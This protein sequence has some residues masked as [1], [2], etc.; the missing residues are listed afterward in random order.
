MSRAL[1][2]FFA[3]STLT[4]CAG[5][6]NLDLIARAENPLGKPG[7]SERP[8]GGETPEGLGP[9]AIVRLPGGPVL[10]IVRGHFR[11]TEECLVGEGRLQLPHRSS[12]S[13]SFNLDF[14]FRWETWSRVRFV[15]QAQAN[16]TGGF[17]L[18]LARSPTNVQVSV[19][20]QGASEDWTD[21]APLQS[22]LARDDV[23]FNLDFHHDEAH[24]QYAHLLF[25]DGDRLVMDSGRDTVGTPGKGSGTSQFLDLENVSLCALQQGAPKDGG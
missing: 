19:E 18:D 3:L 16:G 1:T 10:T 5:G 11:L 21:I 13:D 17:T 20:A 4:A 14:N 24:R 22:L 15:G 8:G 25:Y 23:R 9:G 7:G 6:P 12:V 2:L